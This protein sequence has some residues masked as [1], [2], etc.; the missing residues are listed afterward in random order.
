MEHDP[1]IADVEDA[2]AHLYDLTLLANHPL[3]RALSTDSARFS[4]D[5]LHR[6]L[7]DAVDALNPPPGAP[8]TSASWRRHRYLELRYLAGQ[9]HKLVAAELSL[10]V[11]QAHR[12]QTE[13]VQAV[14]SSLRESSTAGARPP[15]AR[16]RDEALRP[17]VASAPA[18]SQTTLDDELAR[19]G[20]E[21]ASTLNDLVLEVREVL[22]TIEP[23][24]RQRGVAVEADL[25]AVT[26][27]VAVERSL[28][29][30]VIVLLVSYACDPH[31]SERVLVSV[32]LA[33]PIVAL[34]VVF[35]RRDDPAPFALDWSDPRLT[36]T[37]RLAEAVG[38][39]LGPLDGQGYRG[40]HLSLPP[41]KTSTVLAVDDNPD[42][43][44][45]FGAYLE[46]TRY[47]IARAKTGQ[48]A[49]RLAEQSSVDVITLDV[50]MPFQDGW[51]VFRQL[52]ANPATREI[53]VVVCS[54]LPEKDLAFALG[55]T[56]FLAKP[57]TRQTLIT[58]LD[59]CCRAE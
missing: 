30:Q 54:I 9:S 31:L 22:E 37:R 49:L 23:L 35:D 3:G 10:S 26:R 39:S 21:S 36:T 45:L 55:A 4:A 59:R 58:T 7:I 57:V 25:P 32:D 52:R 34:D 8:P 11:R 2:L 38:G 20:R 12:V 27:L 50:M 44:R 5:R 53:P 47:R 1:F 6:F 41:G 24:A 40:L 51:E 14:A 13:A 46:G 48:A 15:P 16:S 29:R 18:S 43:A 56:D 42:L 17:V 19:L 28:L 33:P